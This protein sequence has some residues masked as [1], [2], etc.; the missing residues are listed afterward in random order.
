MLELFFRLLDRHNS[1]FAFGRHGDYSNIFF[2]VFFLFGSLC[3]YHGNSDEVGCFVA[4]RPLSRRNRYYEVRDDH[5]F[6][7]HDYSYN[8]AAVI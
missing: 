4:A 8:T 5:F 2:F 6:S 1:L 7:I 3:R